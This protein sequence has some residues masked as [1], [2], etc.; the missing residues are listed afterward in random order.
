MANQI[1]PWSMDWKKCG[2]LGQIGLGSEL[3][4]YQSYTQWSKI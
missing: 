1:T 2:T 4:D 3:G